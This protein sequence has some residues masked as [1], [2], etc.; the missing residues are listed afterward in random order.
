MQREGARAIESL[1]K[2][3][4]SRSFAK[5]V[6]E[7]S[8]LLSG[9]NVLLRSTRLQVKLWDWEINV[10]FTW[11]VTFHFGNSTFD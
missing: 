1:W 11:D 5:L 3:Q 7:I 4:G 6:D 10:Y 9:K 2:C 8:W